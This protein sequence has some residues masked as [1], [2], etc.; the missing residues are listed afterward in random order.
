MLFAGNTGSSQ[1]GLSDAAIVGVVVAIVVVAA[2]IVVVVVVIVFTRRRRRLVKTR[3]FKLFLLIS[4]MMTL[5]YYGI[6]QE[7]V[8][9]FPYYSI[10]VD[11]F[12]TDRSI[13]ILFD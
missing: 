4:Q 2:I 5:S 9:L 12:V 11:C 7:L 13:H 6:S 8:H 1:P 3:K 10:L